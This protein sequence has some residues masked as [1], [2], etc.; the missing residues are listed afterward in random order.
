[1]LYVEND[2]AEKSAALIEQIMG[3]DY[4]LYWH[5]PRLFNSRNYFGETENVFGNLVSVNM[6]CIPREVGIGVTGK[7]ITSPSDSWKSAEPQ[8]G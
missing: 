8:V 3:L 1:M 5:L 7:E 4:R 2:R 6:L